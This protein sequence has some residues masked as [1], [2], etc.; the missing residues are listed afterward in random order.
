MARVSTIATSFMLVPIALTYL[1]DAKYGLWMAFSSSILMLAGFADGG[2]SNG[3]ISSTARAQQANNPD[4]LSRILSTGFIL[5]TSLAILLIIVILPAGQMINWSGLIDLDTEATAEDAAL[6]FSIVVIALCVTMPVNVTLKFRTGLGRITGVGLWDTLAALSILPS[7]LIV[8]RLDLGLGFFVAAALLSPLLVKAI[9]SITFVVSDKTAKLSYSYFSS[10]TGKKLFSSGFAFLLI[11]M[12]Q[13]IAVNA[14]QM[15]IAIFSGPAEVSPYAI[16]N[17]LFSLPYIAVNLILTVLWPSFAANR[18]AGNF[19][20]I[21]KTYY[22]SLTGCLVAAIAMTLTL[23]YLLPVILDLWINRT[24]SQYP[25]LVLGMTIYGA[26]VVLVGITSTFLVSMEIFRP[27]IYMNLAMLIV[28]FPLT[29]YLV[30]NINA[31][32][33]IWAT[34]I[35]YIVCIALPSIIIIYKILLLPETYLRTTK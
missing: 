21:K 10:A 5:V 13:A 4:Q 3:L 7:V 14:D 15:I 34:L 25:R 17:R 27:Q 20:W 18:E 2:I 35:S 19:N 31:A 32:G 1:G 6:L 26:T 30:K 8:R 16:L 22:K 11:T 9:G 24:F 29:I 28:N 12:T 33:A 23:Y